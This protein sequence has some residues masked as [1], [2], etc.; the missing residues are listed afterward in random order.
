MLIVKQILTN[1][2]VFLSGWVTRQDVSEI[3]IVTHHTYY[4]PMEANQSCMLLWSEER[5]DTIN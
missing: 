1:L 5:T 2:D 3:R 4:K